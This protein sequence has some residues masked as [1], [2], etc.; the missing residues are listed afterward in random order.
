VDLKFFREY[1]YRRVCG[2]SLQPVLDSIRLMK[3]L[4]IWVEITTLV[5]PK[6]NDSR[7]E[8]CS[9]AEF[10][11]SV[12][13][14]I[15]WHISRFHPDYKFTGYPVTPEDTLRMAQAIGN[16]AG[17]NFVYAGNVYGWGG[18]T[19]CPSCGKLLVKREGLK[20]MQYNLREGKCAF[21]GSIIPGVY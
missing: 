21:C 19:L 7:D 3:Q 14:E 12:S 17:L 8:L 18:D 13:K 10:I 2:A 9:I 6:E 1:A 4:N 11:S 16:D 20:V 15:P 5:I